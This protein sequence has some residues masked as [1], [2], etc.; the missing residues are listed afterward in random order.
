MGA[1]WLGEVVEGAG[2]KAISAEGNVQLI[3]PEQWLRLK[4][5]FSSSTLKV[6]R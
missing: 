3:G 6:V 1:E 2:F 5:C 4:K